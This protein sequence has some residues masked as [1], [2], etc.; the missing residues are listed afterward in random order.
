MNFLSA[1]NSYKFEKPSL[2]CDKIPH[3]FQHNTQIFL[4]KLVKDT[5]LTNKDTLHVQHHNM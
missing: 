5:C 1:S 3:R 4:I 2:W